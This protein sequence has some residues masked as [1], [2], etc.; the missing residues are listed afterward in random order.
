MHTN[1]RNSTAFVNYVQGTHIKDLQVL[2]NDPEVFYAIPGKFERQGVKTISSWPIF[3]TVILNDVHYE[4]VPSET[5][6]VS[7][8]E[9]FAQYSQ[10]TLI[11]MTTTANPTGIKARNRKVDRTLAKIRKLHDELNNHLY[12]HPRERPV[13]QSPLDAADLF[14]FFI[15]ALDHEQLWVIN[16]D[17]RNRVMNLTALYKGSVNSSQ[18]RVAE[19]F[20]QA[21]TDNAPAIVLGHNHPSGDI[22]PSPDDVSVTRYVVE[23]GKLL[24]INVLDHIIVSGGE[25]VS[26]KERGLGF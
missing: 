5:S 2:I 24:D 26:M 4:D 17:T 8:K 1:N 11:D 23:A 3:V 9:S 16:L 20:R 18:I 7:I 12:V 21:I 22:N 10:L 6:S 25:Y 15:G 13:I 14:Q 19:V